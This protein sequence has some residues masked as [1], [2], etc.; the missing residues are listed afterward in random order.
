MHLRAFGSGSVHEAG[1]AW[2]V[3]TPVVVGRS[4]SIAAFLSKKRDGTALCVMT[5]RPEVTTATA[6]VSWFFGGGGGGLGGCG[7]PTAA[8]SSTGR[9]VR[10]KP[11][12]F[13]VAVAWKP[14]A[15]I[16]PVS[17]T[18]QPLPTIESEPTVVRSRRVVTLPR[19]FPPSKTRG[20]R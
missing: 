2:T 1:S 19:I 17:F 3:A 10:K 6:P 13:T 5:I 7:G 8:G 12:A 16:G 18:L 9:P 20:T 4:I 11:P 15:S 14:S